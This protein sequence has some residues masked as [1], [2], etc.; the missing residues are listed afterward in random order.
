MEDLDGEEEM[1]KWYPRGCPVCQGDLY[2]DVMDK[3]QVTCMMCGRS[4]PRLPA[5]ARA[6]VQ[7]AREELPEAA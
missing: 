5:D 6:M 4:Y 2:D 3:D 1:M 7:L